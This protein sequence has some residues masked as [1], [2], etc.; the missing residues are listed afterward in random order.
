MVDAPLIVAPRIAAALRRSVVAGLAIA[1]ALTCAPAM[2]STLAP[3]DPRA[4]SH[5]SLIAFADAFD[6]AQ[7]TKDAAALERMISDDLVFIDA[8]GLRKGKK[9]FIAR[10]MTPGESYDPIQLVDRT[11]TPLGPDAGIVGAE[12]TLRGLSGGKPFAS[13]FR[14]ADTFKRTG[15]R[16]LAVHIQVTRIP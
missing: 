16:W 3:E 10:W 5:S 4:E 1:A 2:A 14:F 8:A 15:G 13:H 6:Q 7:L 11:V 12:T 9:D